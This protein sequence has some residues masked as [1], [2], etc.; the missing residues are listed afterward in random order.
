MRSDCK[1]ARKR[2]RK[3]ITQSIKASFNFAMMK[4]IILIIQ[5]LISLTG[6]SIFQKTAKQE[7]TDGYYT[8]KIENKKMK[9]YVDVADENIHIYPTI[10]KEN[11]IIADTTQDYKIYLPVQKALNEKVSLSKA[12]FDID[13]LTIPLKLRFPQGFVP[14]QLNANINGAVFVGYR[15][16][17]YTLRYQKNP[18][19]IS[20]RRIT[21]FGYSAGL[22]SGIGNTFMSPT[23]TN[24]IL[25]QEYDAITWSKGVACILAINNFTLGLSLGFDNLLDK[26]RKIWIYEGK[27]WIG[28]AFGLNLN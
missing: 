14:P 20:E 12:S 23:N 15:T 8:R 1:N 16:D 21:H 28:L 13:F 24:D 3:T 10:K 22:F 27:P 7:L 2:N 4:K 17:N 6:C 26:N 9:V 5:V 11:A 18:L 19:L 25:L